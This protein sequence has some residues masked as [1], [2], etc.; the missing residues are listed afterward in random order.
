MIVM[1]M[2]FLIWRYHLHFE[3]S[4]LKC[5]FCTLTLIERTTVAKV[6]VARLKTNKITLI[7]WLE[8]PVLSFFERAF[9]F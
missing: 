6:A 2:I 9:S 4:P 3:F 8:S 7:Y 5:A 1:T